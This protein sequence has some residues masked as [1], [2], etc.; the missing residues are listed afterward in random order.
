M[1]IR[2]VSMAIRFVSMVVCFVS[3]ADRSGEPKGAV[4]VPNTVAVLRSLI[5]R[6]YLQSTPDGNIENEKVM[7]AP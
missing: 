3:I 5:C 6:G 2:S 7:V 1:V 4:K